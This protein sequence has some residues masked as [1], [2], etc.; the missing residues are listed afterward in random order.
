M[1][2]SRFF[3]RLLLRGSLGLDLLDL[4][5]VARII[6]TRQPM[7]YEIEHTSQ[8]L[9]ERSFCD[10]AAATSASTAARRRL[11][12][13]LRLIVLVHR[14]G[15]GLATLAGLTRLHLGRIPLF[16]FFITHLFAAFIVIDYN[17]YVF[18]SCLCVVY[19]MSLART[20]FVLI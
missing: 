9:I 17:N 13:S 16:R 1:L 11:D 15:R 4:A 6:R 5:A 8:S 3:R 20:H 7:P 12:N 19:S 2:L 10:A 18:S 14:V